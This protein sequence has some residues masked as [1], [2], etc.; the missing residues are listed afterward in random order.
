[1]SD[2]RAR[3]FVALELPREARDALVAWRD[4]LGRVDGMRLLAP[5]A[6]HATLCFIGWRAEAE[7][8]SITESCRVLAGAP[9]PELSLGAALALPRRRPRVLAVTLEDP[10]GTLAAAQ[11]T[12]SSALVAGGWYEPERRPYLPHATVARVGRGAR[13]PGD[14]PSAL[15]QAAFH[16]DRVT[17]Y[18]S[19][20]SRGGARYEPLATLALSSGSA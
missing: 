15:P 17:L 5:S 4:Q 10:S 12:L 7:V 8:D 1:V 18:R 2:E 11:A 9:A 13:L 3:L 14:L 6:L 19:R 16:A 20:L